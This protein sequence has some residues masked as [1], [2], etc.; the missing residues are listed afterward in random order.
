MMAGW[1]L[2]SFVLWEVR[3][4]MEMMGKAYE[5]RFWDAEDGNYVWEIG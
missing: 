3:L 1:D 2:L 4:P 5:G